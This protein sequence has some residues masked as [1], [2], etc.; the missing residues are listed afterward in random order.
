MPNSTVEVTRRK[1]RAPCLDRY[2]HKIFGMKPLIAGIAFLA[3]TQSFACE[4]EIQLNGIENIDSCSG[5]NTV[6]FSAAEKLSEYANKISGG[7]DPDKIVIT[8]ITS[9]WRL[10]DSQMR[11]IELAD[12]IKFIKPSVTP[13]IKKIIF[14][15]SWTGAI[16]RGKLSLAS[17]LSK[18]LGN[19]PVEG[20]DGFIWLSNTGKIRATKNQYTVFKSGKYQ[21]KPESEIMVSLTVGWAIGLE[22]HFIETNNS[23]GLLIAGVGHDVFMLCPTG[24]LQYFQKSA[25]MGNNIAA[26]NA[27]IL[28]LEKR[29]PDNIKKAKQLLLQAAN[30]GD[31]KAQEKLSTLM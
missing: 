21:V 31:K 4:S 23:V 24:A 29:T 27:A 22:K 20:F 8:M 25:E 16:S 11:I 9:P 26:Y 5:Q 6:C 1:W 13:K 14:A 7:D 19:I 15:G 18:S 17:Q 3:A 10:Y 12:F 28:L 30:S 2:I